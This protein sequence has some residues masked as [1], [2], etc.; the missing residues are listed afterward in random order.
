MTNNYISYA[1]IETLLNAV[2]E[3][4]VFMR[5]ELCTKN[6]NL[7]IKA[8]EIEESIN[9]TKNTKDI[10]RV[11]GP[12]RLVGFLLSYYGEHVLN[13]CTIKI[14]NDDPTWNGS[15]KH[16]NVYRLVFNN[17]NTHEQLF[18]GNADYCAGQH[19]FNTKFLKQETRY[20]NG[21]LVDT[22][23]HAYD[24]FMRK[25][26]LRYGIPTRRF[27]FKGPFWNCHNAHNTHGAHYIITITPEA[28]I[29]VFYNQSYE[30][31]V[32]SNLVELPTGNFRIAL[33]SDAQ[34]WLYKYQKLYYNWVNYREVVSR[35]TW[36][37][38]IGGNND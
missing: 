21:T 22:T 31:L 34:E 28:N 14:F 38:F 35:L 12:G 7:F 33:T 24:P 29:R 6:R 11:H 2:F 27:E 13:N 25:S 30:S 37:C 3:K 20:P 8:K 17:G 32:E 9:F 19:D 10:Y 18:G 23:A 1:E 16:N 26:G 5:E 36:D 4:S 15:T